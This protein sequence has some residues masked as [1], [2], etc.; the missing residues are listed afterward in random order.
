MIAAGS[1]NLLLSLIFINNQSLPINN[2]LN[3]LIN[4]LNACSVNQILLSC[5]FNPKMR[6]AFKNI[7]LK[8]FL[9]FMALQILNISVDT[10]EFHPLVTRATSNNIGDFND[11]NSGAE[12]ISEILLG[13]KDAFPEFEKKP[14]SKQSQLLKMLNLKIYHPDTTIQVPQNF[15]DVVSFAYPLDETYSF[16]FSKEINPPPPK[17]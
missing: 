10:I 2:H 3:P 16:L 4:P 6:I 9:A 15:A 11:I 1:S 8:C 13:H 12:Y 17:A 14:G 7:A 5:G